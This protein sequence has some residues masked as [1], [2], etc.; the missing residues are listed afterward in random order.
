M[1]YTK[2][3]W[4]SLPD[5]RYLCAEKHRGGGGVSSAKNDVRVGERVG[6]KAAWSLLPDARYLC[7]EKHRGGGGV[8]SA[9]KSVRVCERVGIM[10]VQRN[11]SRPGRQLTHT[12]RYTH[13][14]THTHTHIYTH[15]I[16]WSK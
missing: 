10:A 7:A 13:T 6:M 8:G 5:A 1:S 4:S 3:A 9:K 11:N 14:H 12:H 15:S 16:H 2:A